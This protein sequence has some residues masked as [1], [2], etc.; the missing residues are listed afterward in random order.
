[1][2]IPVPVPPPR[3]MARG[4][5]ARRLVLRTTAL[6][7]IATIALSF[8]T[9]LA[10]FQILQAQL[11]GRLQSALNASPR[12]PDSGTKPGDPEG[13]GL[14][15]LVQ[16]APGSGLFDST[17]APDALTADAAATLVVLDPADTPVTM[18]V[19]G[20]GLY[21]V[22]VKVDQRG[23]INVAALPFSAV[24]TP[25]TRQLVIAGGL[26]LGAIALSFVGARQVVERSL[27]P[28][29]RLAAAATEVASLP[30]SSGDA[31]LPVRVTAADAD[32][33]NEV[34]RVGAAF[35]RMLDHVEAALAA[36]HRSETRVRQFV[37]DASHELR[38]PL[39]AIRG[40][41]EL[42]LRD[43]DTLPPDASHALERIDAESDRMSALVEDLLLLA[44]LD[45]GPALDLQPTDVTELVLNAVDGARAAG[46]QHSWVLDLPDEIVMARADQ[47][48]L[49]QVVANLLANARVHTP[50]GTRVVT[51]L[52]REGD[53][54]VISVSDNGPGV[55]PEIRDNVFER[56]ARADA[57]RVRQ[58]GG[59]STGLGLAIVAAVVAAHGG[60]VTLDSAP[61]HTTFTVRVP[62]P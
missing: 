5:L 1:M 10:S 14:I 8:F 54:A 21:R 28:L 57:S 12:G 7:A 19:E 53:Q 9:A 42:T 51:R 4:T 27:R 61:G 47:H 25:L 50:P 17:Q 44:R 36:R 18:G 48:R 49:Y 39:A 46:P 43:A 2:T 37:A 58:A 62:S 41:T 59:S 29:N 34:G 20:L 30:L 55:P 31:H 6:V 3:P 26:T 13:S 16:R 56:F 23:R 38:N 11:D 45:S 32:P 22:L 52:R 40:Y 60:T 35:N 24:I 33:S 15:R